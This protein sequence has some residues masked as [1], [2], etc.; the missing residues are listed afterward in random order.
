MD[1]Y[2]TWYDST[3]FSGVQRFLC[4]VLDEDIVNGFA[5]YLNILEMSGRSIR[6]GENYSEIIHS[7]HHAFSY[8]RRAYYA[9][10]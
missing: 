10:I 4:A 1:Y 7:T 6:E 3:I 9:D 8:M 2:N 5:M